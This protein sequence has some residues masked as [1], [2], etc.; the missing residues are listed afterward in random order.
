VKFDF[1]PDPLWQAGARLPALL[2]EDDEDSE[3]HAEE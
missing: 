1:Q 3:A 2:S